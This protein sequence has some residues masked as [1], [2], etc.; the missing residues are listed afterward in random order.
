M[1]ATIS[2]AVFFVPYSLQEMSVCD[3]FFKP[4]GKTI[5][6]IGVALLLLQSVLLPNSGV[7]KLLNTPFLIWIG[8]LSYSLYIWQQLFS[9]P[10]QLFGFNPVWWMSFPAWMLTTMAVACASYYFL[11]KPFMAL[12]ARLRDV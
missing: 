10:T 5:E 7:Y 9:A 4:F 12:R 6:G 3:G 11:E 1:V 8:T 2:F